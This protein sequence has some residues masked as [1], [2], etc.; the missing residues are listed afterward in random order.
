[1]KTKTLILLAAFIACRALAGDPLL[2]DPKLTPGD[3][4][5]NVTVEQLCTRG[6]ANVLNGGARNVPQ[7]EKRSVFVEYFGSV[8]TNTK[9]FEID[10]LCPVCLGGK[11][12]TNNLWPE[13]GLTE[14]WNYHVKDRLEDHLYSSLKADL[15]A[16]GHDHATALWHEYQTEIMANWTNCY[17]KHLGDPLQYKSGKKQKHLD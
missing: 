9:D 17:V 11:N 10:H 15:T 13:S 2:P 6:Y 14:I 5:T 8:P 16:N 12:D 3:V 4:L 7:S 1:M